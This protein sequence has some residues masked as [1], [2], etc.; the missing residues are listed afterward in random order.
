MQLDVLYIAIK[1]FKP[2]YI[3]QQSTMVPDIVVV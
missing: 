3:I 2:L 1:N